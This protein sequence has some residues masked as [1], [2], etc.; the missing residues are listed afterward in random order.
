M[1]NQLQ[2]ERAKQSCNVWSSY[3]AVS[4]RSAPRAPRAPLR[5]P[6]HGASR[7]DSLE[8]LWK[9]AELEIQR[10][11]AMAQK[12]NPWLGFGFPQSHQP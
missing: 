3:R 10:R 7:D 12:G 1:I 9:E 6:G 8:D 2:E 4:S 5:G 11:R